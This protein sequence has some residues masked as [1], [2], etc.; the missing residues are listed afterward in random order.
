[1]FKQGY[2]IDRKWTVASYAS[3]NKLYGKMLVNFSLNTEKANTS[4]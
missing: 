3:F 1:M 4:S 2:Q